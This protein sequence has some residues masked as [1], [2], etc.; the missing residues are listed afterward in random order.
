[1][2]SFGRSARFF[3]T[4]P[5]FFLKELMIDGNSYENYLSVSLGRNQKSIVFDS[6]RYALLS[7]WLKPLMIDNMS[8]RYHPH[9]D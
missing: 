7:L 5:S 1:M 2:S 8:E 6:Y 3:D 9:C 4:L